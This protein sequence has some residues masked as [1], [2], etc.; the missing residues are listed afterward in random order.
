MIKAN[1]HENITAGMINDTNQIPKT[2]ILNIITSLINQTNITPKQLK[3]LNIDF[4]FFPFIF[5]NYYK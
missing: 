4:Y 1:F 3:N 2:T 5:Y